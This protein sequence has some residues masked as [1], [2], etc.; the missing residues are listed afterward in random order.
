MKT[1][2]VVHY[3]VLSTD[4]LPKR[5]LEEDDP[6][7]EEDDFRFF[8]VRTEN[9]E[10]IEIIGT[11]GGEPEDQLLVRDWKWVA[12]ALNNA[13]KRGQQ[14]ALNTNTGDNKGETK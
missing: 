10:I 14:N 2:V 11:D 6:C 12:P 3:K 13:Y 4:E 8:L 7:F 9:N 5:F 1:A